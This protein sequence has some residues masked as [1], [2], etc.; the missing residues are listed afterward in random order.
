MSETPLPLDR[1]CG[2]AMRAAR[3]LRTARERRSGSAGSERA[4]LLARRVGRVPGWFGAHVRDVLVA[5]ELHPRCGD[6]QRD[7]G[8]LQTML[9]A[10]ASLTG[11]CLASA[12]PPFAQADGANTEFLLAL[13]E[14]MGAHPWTPVAGPAEPIGDAVGGGGGHVPADPLEYRRGIRRSRLSEAAR[15][16]KMRMQPAPAGMLDS[17][18]KAVR[19]LY[20]EGDALKHCSPKRVTRTTRRKTGLGGL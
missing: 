4:K 17:R 16:G 15:S 7:L 1:L 5:Y 20:N 2:W 13:A 19:V 6:L 9:D 10:L 8:D 11:D 12:H 18:G 3:A 14:F